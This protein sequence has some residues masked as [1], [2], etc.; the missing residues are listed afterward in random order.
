MLFYVL[1]PLRYESGKAERFMLF[2]K[3]CLGVKKYIITIYFAEACASGKGAP[4]LALPHRE[5]GV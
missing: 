3:S 2:S 5:G 4:P 1:S